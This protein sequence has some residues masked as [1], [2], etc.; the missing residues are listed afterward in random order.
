MSVIIKSA[1]DRI[2]LRNQ[3][4]P[5]KV[6][7]EVKAYIM[8]QAFIEASWFAFKMSGRDMYAAIIDADIG[9]Q[10]MAIHRDDLAD[11]QIIRKFTSLQEIQDNDY[12]LFEFLNVMKDLI[13]ENKD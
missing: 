4:Q 6:D 1:V 8:E 2:K 5:S 7:L 3:T 12:V 11:V 9:V 13:D 10:P